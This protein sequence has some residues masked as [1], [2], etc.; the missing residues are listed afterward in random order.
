MCTKSI[1][2]REWV[3]LDGEA[4]RDEARGYPKLMGPWLC[5]DS[6]ALFNSASVSENYGDHKVVLDRIW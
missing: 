1:E 3:V 5:A 4:D 6:S 2:K